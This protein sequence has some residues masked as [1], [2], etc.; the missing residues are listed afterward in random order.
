MEES[1]LEHWPWNSDARQCNKERSRPLEVQQGDGIIVGSC[2]GWS[3]LFAAG[4]RLGT[5]GWGMGVSMAQWSWD[6]QPRLKN[7]GAITSRAERGEAG[8]TRMG[9]DT[10]TSTKLAAE[11]WFQKWLGLFA[12]LRTGRGAGPK[13]GTTFFKNGLGRLGI[14][15]SFPTVCA[16]PCGGIITV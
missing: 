16:Y 9:T 15:P 10:A 4:H 13:N 14:L 3:T 1:L 5:W 7:F 2:H 8:G 11:K 12:R 6:G